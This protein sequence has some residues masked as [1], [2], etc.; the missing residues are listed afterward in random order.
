MDKYFAGFPSL[1]AY[2]DQTIKD[3]R[4]K[5]YSRTE[6]GR[7]RPFPDIATATGRSARRPSAR[8]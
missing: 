4:A 1:R 2:M 3:I 6:F 5:G 7:I 8:R